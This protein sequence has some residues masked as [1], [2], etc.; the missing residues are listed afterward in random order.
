MTRRAIFSRFITAVLLVGSIAFG[1]RRDEIRDR[2]GRLIGTIVQ[3]RD[4]VREARNRQWR[5]LG[6]Y[7]P[8]SNETRDRVGELLT[9]GD[10]L[11]ALI[12]Q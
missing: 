4:G 11:S 2:Q 9:R 8:K 1:Q 6:T 5:L 3:R 10:T 12:W 7:N